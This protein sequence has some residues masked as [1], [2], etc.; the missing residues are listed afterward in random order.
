MNKIKASKEVKELASKFRSYIEKNIVE[1]R[2]ALCCVSLYLHEGDP[3]VRVEYRR[4]LDSYKPLGACN[5]SFWW[6]LNQNWGE[7]TRDEMLICHNKKRIEILN[8]II[9]L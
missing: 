7:I 4:V 5:D 6:S 2:V 9:N 3:R 1:E 8:Q